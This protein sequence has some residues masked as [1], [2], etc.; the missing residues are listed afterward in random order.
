MNQNIADKHEC[1]RQLDLKIEHL[2]NAE[3]TTLPAHHPGSARNS[4]VLDRPPLRITM[5]GD[6]FRTY[7]AK[8]P[9][10]VGESLLERPGWRHVDL[11]IRG[12]RRLSYNMSDRGELDIY[13]FQ[14]GAWMKEIFDVDPMGDSIAILPHLFADDK[15]PAWRAFRNSPLSNWPPRFAAE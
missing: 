4:V 8:S 9:T 13:H 11:F 5:S 2:L 1:V 14:P 15:D 7:A 12:Q 10:M 3:G 6:R